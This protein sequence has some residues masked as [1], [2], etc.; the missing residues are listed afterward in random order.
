MSGS[1]IIGEPTG[2]FYGAAFIEKDNKLFNSTDTGIISAQQPGPSIR[3]GPTIKK[4]EKKN[5]K[6]PVFFDSI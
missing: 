1:L 2:D 6:F 4:S 5:N 3:F